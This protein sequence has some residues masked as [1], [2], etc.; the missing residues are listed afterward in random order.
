MT[1]RRPRVL[2]VGA[3]PPPFMG[4]TLATE[5]ILRSSLRD[6]FELIH[7]DTSDHRPLDTLGAI[8]FQ[9][10]YLALRSYVIMLAMLLRYWPDLVYIPISQTTLGY[11]KD[12]ALIILAKLFR[13]KVL[14]HLR[15]G[16]FR[17]WL[18]SA[19]GLT[20]WYVRVVHSRV[21]G[22]IVLGEKLRPLFSEL[23]PP[24]R[25]HVVPNG[26]D[27]SY[28]AKAPPDG[29]IR[30]LY[31]ANMVRTKGVLDVLHAA[32]LIIQACPDTEI[33]FGGAW[34]D[35][36][37]RAE[38]DSFLSANPGLPIRWAGSVAGTAKTSLINS[39]DIFV[40][41]TYYPFEGHPWVIVEALAAGLPVISTDQG[42][43]T[44]S[45][46]DGVN[47]YIVAKR[48]PAELAARTIELIR[49]SALRAAMGAASQRLYAEQ[50][51]EK[52]MTERLA[53]S[54]HAVIGAGSRRADTPD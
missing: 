42:A 36:A 3:V 46:I 48:N 49:N 14:C 21:D 33:V 31:L 12:S 22:Q 29:R 7:L 53:D 44:E 34:E 27:I 43:I 13:R 9:N 2:L 8:D 41:P 10:I 47:G 35:P 39:A 16:Y 50:F 23:L 26:K 18:A 11:V 19:S 4:P 37:V 5:V 45:V 25:V 38:V 54:F 1:R 30:V 28:P 6:K 32:P 20:R 17:E 24:Q 15:G 40:F 52:R 51:T